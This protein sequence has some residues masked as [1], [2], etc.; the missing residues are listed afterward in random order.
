MPIRPDDLDFLSFSG[1][2]EE[3]LAE[4]DARIEAEAEADEEAVIKAEEKDKK[5]T[6]Q[7][8]EEKEKDTHFGSTVIYGKAKYDAVD[9]KSSLMEFKISTP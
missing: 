8:A 3:I 1:T 9:V 4:I 7:A 5:E 2:I 6:T